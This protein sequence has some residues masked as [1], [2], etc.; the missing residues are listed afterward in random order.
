MDD[1]DEQS[2][3]QGSQIRSNS[4]PRLYR[5]EEQGT[6]SRAWKQLASSYCVQSRTP[7]KQGF[8]IDLNMHA[9]VYVVGQELSSASPHGGTP[10]S[11]SK[12]KSM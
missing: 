7:T 10:K 12:Q 6:L 2:D 8:P 3:C 9:D 4:T 1:H 5:E 11:G